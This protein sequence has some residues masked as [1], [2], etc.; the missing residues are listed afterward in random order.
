MSSL[1]HQGLP[2]PARGCTER[3]LDLRIEQKR[4]RVFRLVVTVDGCRQVLHVIARST[5]DAALWAMETL[6]ADFVS[7]KPA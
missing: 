3:D 6:G 1:I 4:A 5:A 7:V 2:A